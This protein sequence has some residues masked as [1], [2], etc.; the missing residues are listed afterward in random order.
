MTMSNRERIK[1]YLSSIS[2]ILAFQISSFFKRFSLSC[3]HKHN[4]NIG[5]KISCLCDMLMR[6][7]EILWHDFFVLRHNL[8]IILLWKRDSKSMIYNLPHPEISSLCY[9][10]QS[11]TESSAVWDWQP[12]EQLR[13]FF[14]QFLVLLVVIRI[15]NTTIN[16]FENLMFIQDRRKFWQIHIHCKY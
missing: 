4:I 3:R 9:T 2:S 15:Q 16:R 10:Y 5:K 7:L 12:S 11:W 6:Q 13:K 1:A 14:F 8:C